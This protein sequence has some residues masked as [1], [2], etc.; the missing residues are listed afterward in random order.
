MEKYRVS[1]G[2]SWGAEIRCIG[3]WLTR[4]QIYVVQ[5]DA[6]EHHNYNSPS[7][8]DPSPFYMHE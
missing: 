8:R 7:S 5:H 4:T 6:S 3:D 1:D 2:L